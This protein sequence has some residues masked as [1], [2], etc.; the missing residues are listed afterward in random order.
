VPDHE[1]HLGAG[2][3]APV[4]HGVQHRVDRLGDLGE[5]EVLVERAAVRPPVGG[6]EAAAEHVADAVVEEVDL[7]GAGDLRPR[8]ARE[9]PQRPQDVGLLEEAHVV[10]D[11]VVADTGQRRPL[12]VVAEVADPARGQF[13]DPAE[14]RQALD[15]QAVGGVADDERLDETRQLLLRPVRE[16]DGRVAAVEE[17]PARHLGPMAVGERPRARQRSGDLGDRQRQEKVADGAP[18]EG[19]AGRR[20]RVERGAARRVEGR[21]RPPIDEP[22]LDLRVRPGRLPPVLLRPQR[23]VDT[24]VTQYEPPPPPEGPGCRPTARAPVQTRSA[25]GSRREKARPPR[26]T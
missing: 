13:E 15:A 9:R 4:G 19:L 7:A 21:S 2:L 12:G 11:G 26:T 18:G 24:T 10:V 17:H 22:L 6:P 1:V 20:L 3:A 16:D 5:D 8:A 25:P 14:G 23:V